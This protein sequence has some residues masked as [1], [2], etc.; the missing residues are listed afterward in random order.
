VAQALS[1]NVTYLSETCGLDSFFVRI[2]V[3]KPSRKRQRP[4]FGRK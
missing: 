2:V 3:L 4:M 1:P